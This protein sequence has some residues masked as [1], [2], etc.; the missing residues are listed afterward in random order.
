MA[1]TSNG[2]RKKALHR[3]VPRR[4]LST[5]PTEPLKKS[6]HKVYALSGNLQLCSLE[7]LQYAGFDGVY[8]ATN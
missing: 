2:S 6:S 8:P 3:D 7:L 1:A 4:N 5:W